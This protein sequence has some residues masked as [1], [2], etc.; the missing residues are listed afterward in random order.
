YYRSLFTKL[1]KNGRIQLFKARRDQPDDEVTLEMI[2][3]RLIIHGTPDSVADQLLAFQDEVGQFGTLL[4]AG[5]DWKDREL[6]R[7]SMILMA[8][9]VLPRVNAGSSD[10]SNAAE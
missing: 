5:K 9:K 1:K 3:D 4:Y 8:E 6:G 7:Q 10:R 2:C